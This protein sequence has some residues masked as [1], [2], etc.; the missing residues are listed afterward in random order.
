MNILESRLYRW[1]EILSNFFLLNILWLLVSIPLITIF[2]ATAAMFAIVRDWSR[3]KETAIF[4]PFFRYF[5]EN[6]VQ[7]LTVGVVWVTLGLIIFVEYRFVVMVTSWAQIPLL[8]FL[9]VLVLLYLGTA[10]F[11]FPVMVHFQA[12]WT[13][14]IR[15]SFLI[16]VSSPLKTFLCL[17]I[18]SVATLAVLFFPLSFLL[19][20]SVTA[21]FLYR[22]AHTIFQKVE[23]IDGNKPI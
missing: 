20:S 15:N 13:Q 4:R 19:T 14:I 21:Y 2:P 7:S 11:I 16:S 17:L 1:L 12:G 3:G 23:E 9:F 10:V 8:A 5:R 22:I 6:I 18:I